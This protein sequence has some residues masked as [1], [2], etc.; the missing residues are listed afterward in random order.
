MPVPPPWMKAPLGGAGAPPPPPVMKPPAAPAVAVPPAAPAAPAVAV[1]PAAPAAPAVAIPPAAPAAPAVAVPPA[2]PAAP[3]V[4]A[5]PAAPAAPAVSLP[6]A[7]PVA[8]DAPPISLPTASPAASSLAERTPS[9]GIPSVRASAGRTFSSEKGR[10]VSKVP[11]VPVLFDNEPP[12]D[13]NEEPVT[14]DRYPKVMLEPLHVLDPLCLKWGLGKL[15]I[16]VAVSPAEVKVEKPQETPTPA[17]PPDSAPLMAAD[18]APPVPASAPI[19]PS[20]KLAEGYLRLMGLLANGT[21]W[22]YNIPLADMER[23]GGVAI[24]RDP[25]LCQIVLME[26]SISRRHASLILTPHGVL[27]KDEG[28]T[29]GT[30]VNGQRLGYYDPQMILRDGN[31][32]GLGD[33]SLRVEIFSSTNSYIPV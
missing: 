29:N 24:G 12:S 16:P 1:P 25:S 14:D 9:R 15:S 19:P 4:A 13:E 5:P 23:Q 33:V 8:P 11:S 6:K 21:P 30:F 2:A 20:A 26:S 22:E 17:P 3:A 27:L 10:V 18:P 28:S 7:S 32:I 31:V